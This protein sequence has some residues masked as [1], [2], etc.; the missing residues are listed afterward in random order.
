M[1]TSSLKAD[2]REH[3]KDVKKLHDADLRAGNGRVY[4]AECAVPEVSKC[5]CRA[6]LAVR[7]SGAGAVAR[8]AIWRAPASPP[9][10]SHPPEGL[11]RCRPHGRAREAG[12][13]PHLAPLLRHARPDERLRHPDSARA[14][15]PQQCEDDD[16]LPPRPQ[17]WRPWREEPGRP[18]VGFRPPARTMR[19]SPLEKCS[20]SHAQLNRTDKPTLPGTLSVQN[21]TYK[22]RGL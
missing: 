13:L 16:D 20:H 3:L 5:R 2:L 9:I 14:P 17:P 1:L 18:P 11:P 22:L 8:S 12:D 10:R 4:L 21:R 15:R 19:I 6:G 7:V